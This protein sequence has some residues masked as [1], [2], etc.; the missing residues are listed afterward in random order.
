MT[1]NIYD[2]LNRLEATF[3]QTEQFSKVEQAIEEVKNDEEAL[4]LFKNFREIQLT[5]QE[6]QMAGEEVEADELEHAQKTAQL[7]QTNAKIMTMLEAE[8]QLSGLIEEV[9]RVLMKPVQNMYESI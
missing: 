1:V 8:M 2:D 7:A 3:R 5:L 9:N 4:V 6:K